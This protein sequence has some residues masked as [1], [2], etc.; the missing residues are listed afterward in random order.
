MDS[1]GYPTEE[2]LQMIRD[3]DVTTKDGYVALMDYI[4]AQCWYYPEFIVNNG[5]EYTLR[6]G[7]WSGCEDVIGA[8]QD[9]KMF[10]IFYWKSSTRGG[11]HIFSPHGYVAQQKGMK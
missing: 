1:D 10:W 3:W 6:T 9:N 11:K 8:L 5:L 4:K 2:E 7:G